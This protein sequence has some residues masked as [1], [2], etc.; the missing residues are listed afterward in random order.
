MARLF[1]D[2]T[3]NGSSDV[4]ELTVPSGAVAVFGTFD[5]ATITISV[6]IDNTNF[7]DSEV[8]TTEGV[9]RF[10]FI[11]G[12]YVKATLSDAGASTSISVDIREE[13]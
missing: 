6:S 4:Y 5:G 13:V 8:F 11:R 10:D 1:T 12:G 9:K 7:I 2:K 3:E